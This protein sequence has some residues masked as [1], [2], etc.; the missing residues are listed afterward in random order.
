MNL[1]LSIGGWVGIGVAVVIVAVI[2]IWAIVTYNKFISLGV[3][4]DG[5]LSGIDVYLKKRYDLI[6]NVVE[7]VK[8]YA[9]HE[10]ETL[11]GITD[12]R[13]RM[14]SATTAEEKIQAD[15]QLTQALRSFNVVMERY[16]ELKANANFLELQGQLKDIEQELSHARR[17]YNACVGEWNKKIKYF[18]SIIIANIMRLQPRAMFKVEN[19]EE[20]KNIQVKF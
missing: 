16:P 3:N 6:P 2:L 10:K 5:G 7:T 13:A 18:P 8:G 4:C 15:A 19:P 14:G 9:K 11:Q 17:Y 1:L 20:T 12:A